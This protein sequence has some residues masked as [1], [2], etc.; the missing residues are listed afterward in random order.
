MVYPEEYD[1]DEELL[2]VLYDVG[3]TLFNEFVFMDEN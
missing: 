3:E 1:I 2:G